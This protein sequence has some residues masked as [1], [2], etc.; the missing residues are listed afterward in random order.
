MPE[1][2]LT[3]CRV[4][5]F[6]G[7]LTAVDQVDFEVYPGEV[8]ALLGDNGAG[9]STLIKCISGVYHPEQGEVMFEGHDITG[10]SPAD[11][12]NRGIETIYQDLSLAE[13]LDVG[14]NVFL[15]Q[16]KTK[17]LFGFIPVTDDDYM[18]AEAEKVLARLDIRIPS[19][20]QKL[21]N[22]SGGQRQRIGIARALYKNADVIIFDEATSAL[23]N[24]TEHAVMEVIESLG[25]TLTLLIIAH[26]LTTLRNC[27]QIV[28]LG[29]GGIRRI[30]TYQSIV[31]STA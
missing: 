7:G 14:A 29:D 5:K 18:R 25:E 30:G 11:V 20:K 23:D 27:S 13:K 24:E 1:P 10:H 4:S 12:R 19:L 2:I 3:A 17:L 31:T 15:G 8:V 6:F 9:K 26:R 16:E 21:V 28:E 22:L